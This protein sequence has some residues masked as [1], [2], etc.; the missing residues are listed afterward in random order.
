MIWNYRDDALPGDG[1]VVTLQW[2]NIPAKKCTVQQLRIDEEHSNAYEAWKK[3]GS[4]QSVTREQYQAL[5]KAGMLQSI[6]ERQELPVT[7][8]GEA[9]LTLTLPLHAVTLLKLEW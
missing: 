9:A 2:K 8:N 7:G 5:E 3:M 4:P 1:S 6:A